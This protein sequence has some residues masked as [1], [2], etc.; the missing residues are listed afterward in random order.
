MA[1]S[2]AEIGMY[3]A[4]AL[5]LLGGL[6]LRKKL[7]RFTFINAMIF[8]AGAVLTGAVMSIHRARGGQHLLGLS[9]VGE[10]RRGGLTLKAWKDGRMGVE[11]RVHLL[12]GLVAE[13]VRDPVMRKLS[14]GITKGCPARDEICEAK[15][16]FGHVVQN[17]R[18]T[19]DVGE[20]VVEPG[21]KP[22]AVDLFVTAKRALDFGGDDCDGHAVTNATLGVQNGFPAK[23]R[24]TSNE[25]RSWDH[26]YAMFGVPK[27]KPTRWIAI[28][29]TLGP[30]AF[31][32]E[33]K[34]AKHVDF[35]A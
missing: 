16:I 22:E 1:V 13:G 30:S 6:L 8:G 31:D 20:H 26:I 25:G 15:A 33:P 24:I 21:G 27:L 28:D 7:D 3:S 11:E 10:V 18:Y 14:L 2:K 9:Q 19:G 5:G 35:P 4:G 32:K 34:Q 29:T 12:Q 23:F 17:V